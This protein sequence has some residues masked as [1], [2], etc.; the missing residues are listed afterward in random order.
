MS[1]VTVT[2]GARAVNAERVAS[3][4]SVERAAMD[5]AL[6]QRR[7]TNHAA[8]A[9][10][11]VSID[12]A[13]A[14]LR[15]R[16][17]LDSSIA[18][19]PASARSRSHGWAASQEAGERGGRGATLPGAPVQNVALAGATSDV[20]RP[21]AAVHSATTPL[22]S[23]LSLSN[24]LKSLVAVAL[25]LILF[26]S[27]LGVGLM[28]RPAPFSGQTLVHSVSS[29]ESVWGLASSL[30]LSRPLESVVED[31]YALNALSDA[32]LQPGQQI[33]LPAE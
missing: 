32:T 9:G 29:G 6:L 10:T 21:P 13:R 27:A 31:I 1:A 11:V 17:D 23:L 33:I 26:A 7:Q 4:S 12:E 28:L 25:T 14:R 22:V 3:V 5:T 2:A 15:G 24:V 16:S 20:A 18:R 19:H 8:P 30:G